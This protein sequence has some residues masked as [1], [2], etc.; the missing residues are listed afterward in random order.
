[1]TETILVCSDLDSYMSK[2][3]A[4]ARMKEPLHNND[5]RR[6]GQA[7]HYPNLLYYDHDF[8]MEGR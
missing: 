6:W 3:I 8:A 1:V 2:P 4:P 7:M 5:I